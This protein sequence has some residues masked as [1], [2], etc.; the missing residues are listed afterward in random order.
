[1]WMEKQHELARRIYKNF[2]IFE[3]TRQ[4]PIAA[5]STQFG[6]GWTWLVE[7]PGALRIAKLDLVAVNLVG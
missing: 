7:E 4:Q 6:G 3:E 2:G 1:M 5:A